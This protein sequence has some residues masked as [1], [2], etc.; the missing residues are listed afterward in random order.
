L[1]NLGGRAFGGAFV[2]APV[3][4]SVG[5]PFGGGVF[6]VGNLGFFNEAP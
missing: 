3:G 2:G 6:V 5:I 1:R 4:I